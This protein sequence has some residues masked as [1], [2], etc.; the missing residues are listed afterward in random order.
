[1]TIYIEYQLYK[2]EATMSSDRE[3]VAKIMGDLKKHADFLK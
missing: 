3:V 2:K 1:L